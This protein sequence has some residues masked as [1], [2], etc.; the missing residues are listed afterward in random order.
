MLEQVSQVVRGLFDSPDARDDACRAAR[1]ISSAATVLLYETDADSGRLICTATAGIHRDKAEIVADPHGSAGQALRT[2]QPVLITQDV[3][4]YIG[5]TQE[6]IA[7]GRPSSLL[8]QPLIRGDTHLGVLV[9]C[10][11]SHIRADGPRATMVA[12]LAHEMAARIPSARVEIVDGA[13]H[14]VHLE[15]PEAVSALL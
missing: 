7:A 13:G 2:A 5:N 4:A 1:T 6:W 11:P 8:Y 10:W 15:A 12:L 3:E 14:Q 9:V